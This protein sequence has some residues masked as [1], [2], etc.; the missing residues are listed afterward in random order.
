[1]R[2]LRSETCYSKPFISQGPG[3]PPATP[4]SPGFWL[5]W[6][7]RRLAH[8]RRAKG[9]PEPLRC[10]PLPPT[11]LRPLGQ[12]DLILTP[13]ARSPTHFKV[14]GTQM[15]ISRSWCGT[16]RCL[17]R[18]MKKLREPSQCKCKDVNK[19]E[20]RGPWPQS[21]RAQERT[22]PGRS[23]H[24]SQRH[25]KPPRGLWKDRDGRGSSPAPSLERQSWR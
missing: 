9:A 10:Q 11:H 8:L 7:I 3:C 23:A 20:A 6:V 22:H 2:N 14:R 25:F 18:C 12:P 15:T 16:P 13:P 5:A 21:D 17:A 24:W 1:M 4:A 19:A